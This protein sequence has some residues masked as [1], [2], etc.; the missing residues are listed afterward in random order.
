[1]SRSWTSP[2]FGQAF[3]SATGTDSALVFSIHLRVG[4]TM[5]LPVTSTATVE[6]ILS[7][8]ISGRQTS[9]SFGIKAAAVSRHRPSFPV[10]RRRLSLQET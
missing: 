5:W 3:C 2:R 1:M 8:P 10:E 9:R 4:P 6:T 7:V